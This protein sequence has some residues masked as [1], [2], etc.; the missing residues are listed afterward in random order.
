ML[1]YADDVGSK[2]TKTMK[3]MYTL[4]CLLLVIVAV[5]AQNN[6]PRLRLGAKA[7][8]NLYTLGS[9]EQIVDDDTG[10]GY[11]LGI[12]GRIG[13]RLY[14]QPGLEFVNY[15]LHAVTVDQPRLGERDA[16]AVRYL[17]VPVMLGHYIGREGR[18]GTRLRAMVGPSYSFVLDVKDNNLA[19]GRGDLRNSQ[20]ALNGGLGYDLWVLNIDLIYHHYLSTLFDASGAEGRGRAFSL[21]AGLSF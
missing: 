20:F 12:F 15:K 4:F 11:E 13:D 18:F 21:S 16:L 6:E 7:G 19:V 5:Q 17:R 8:I 10:L 14:L 1:L 9:D 3:T 2:S